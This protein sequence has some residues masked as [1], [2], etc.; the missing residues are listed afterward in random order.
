MGET[1]PVRTGPKPKP[2]S[3]RLMAKV[4]PEPNSGCWLWMG[5]T[6]KNGYGVI[7]VK[8]DPSKKMAI[9]LAHRISYE[10]ANGAIPDG[11]QLDHKCRVR[12]CVNP[13][14]LRAVTQRGNL[15]CGMGAS[16]VNSRKTHCKHGHELTPQNTYSYPGT[17]WRKCRTCSKEKPWL[18]T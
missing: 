6:M 3:D 17:E 13:D 8:E 15:L 4:T 1:I 14:H 7:G 2:V 11:M 5:H 12:C 9:R 18:R 16:G 10:L